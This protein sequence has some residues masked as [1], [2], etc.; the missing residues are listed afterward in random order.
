MYRS[1]HKLTEA[2]ELRRAAMANC[3]EQ[4]R[5]ELEVTFASLDSR[6]CDLTPP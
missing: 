1:V 2:E 4:K 5:A 3:S 6:S